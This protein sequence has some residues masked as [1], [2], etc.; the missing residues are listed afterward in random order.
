MTTTEYAAPSTHHRLGGLLAAAGLLAL[1]A[2]VPVLLVAVG[3]LFWLGDLTWTSFELLVTSPDDGTLLLMAMIVTGWAVWAWLTAAVGIEAVARLRNVRAPRIP[4]L[5]Q[6]FAARALGAAW[7]VGAGALTASQAAAAPTMA[8]FAASTSPIDATATGDAAALDGTD[9]GGNAETATDTSTPSS[10]NEYV[11]AR[12]DSLWKIADRL[13]SDGTRWREIF[14][15]NQNRLGQPDFILPGT[16]LQIPTPTEPSPPAQPDIKT[17]TVQHGDT[18]TGIARDML[19]DP[20]RYP[21]IVAASKNTTQPDGRRLTDP[22]HIEPGWTLTIP[23]PDGG[24][25]PTSYEPPSDSPKTD[26]TSSPVEIRQPAEDAPADQAGP[27]NTAPDTPWSKPH[28]T[29]P[30]RTPADT[31]GPE[32]EP[33]QRG[34]RDAAEEESELDVP[35]ALVP[36]LTGAGAILAAGLWLSLR[37]K[38]ALQLRYRRP[39]RAIQP[40]LSTPLPVEHTLRASGAPVLPDV[41]RLDRLLLALAGVTEDTTT[42]RPPL[43]AVELTEADAIL[44]FAEPVD[45]PEPWTGQNT[46]WTTSLAT[47]D[48]LPHHLPGYRPYPMLATLGQDEAGH[49]WLLDLERTRHLLVTGDPD[50][51]TDL[52]RAIAA[53][54]A[55]NPWTQNLACHLVGFDHAPTNLGFDATLHSHD[56]ADR[57]WIDQIT[58]N[59]QW[60]Y[61]ATGDDRE[62]FHAVIATGRAAS[63]PA[64]ASLA[65][66]LGEHPGRPGGVV[67]TIGATPD[68]GDTVAHVTAGRVRY[69]PLGLDLTST[70]LTEAELAAATAIAS[71]TQKTFEDVPMPVGEAA[72]GPPVTDVAGAPAPAVVEPRPETPDEPAGPRSI[73]PAPG[74]EYEAT[75]VTDAEELDRIAPIV[76]SNTA[77][78]MAGSDPQLN[79]DVDEWLGGRIIRPRLMLLGPVALH[80]AGGVTE[81]AARH[82][83]RLIEYATYLWHHPHGTAT[84]RLSDALGITPSRIRKDIGDLRKWLGNNPRTGQPRVPSARQ[85]DTYRDT[86][87]TGYQI[88]DLLVDADL[89]LRLR[90]RAHARGA[91]GITDLHT[92]LRLVRGRPYDMLRTHGWS[93]LLDG[94]RHDLTLTHAITD[95]A[96]TVYLQAIHDGDHDLARHACNVGLT[97][98][99][100]DEILRLD[101]ANLENTLGHTDA[102]ERIVRDD[103]EGW[104]HHGLAGTDLPART[105][106]ALSR[107]RGTWDAME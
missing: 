86:G 17:Y 38:R 82:K 49:L 14:D 93:W 15:L 88:H 4:A 58:E 64:I 83:A 33:A 37:R 102:A 13:W 95:I 7:A 24:V 3:R 94:E 67:I 20:N 73:L 40:G 43:T 103:I 79:D 59:V 77:E 78:T 89:L 81:D 66:A 100:E 31:S 34:A 32:T 28:T 60:H 18:L 80:V 74:A 92:A 61:D 30:D 75:G 36:G 98:V 68:P 9:A 63:T 53:E 87:N 71:L 26:R 41:E 25:E 69:A 23:A 70:G 45:L 27:S 2:G 107:R 11:V 16:R 48:D 5:P 46:R 19:G 96:H 104:E 72:D 21:D 101:L 50:Q 106:Q 29:A 91:D 35:G 62:E 8:T 10:T 44:H 65:T 55:V 105:S 57:T 22:D 54:L 12:G 76:A 52:A 99:P 56:P 6:G 85:G 42:P 51:A 39:G 1:V 47:A 84:E 97:A 90:K